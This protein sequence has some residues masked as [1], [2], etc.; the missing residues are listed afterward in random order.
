MAT[1]F[2]NKMQVK[3][4]SVIQQDVRV[5]L[6][7]NAVSTTLAALGDVDTLSLD[8]I[9]ESKVEEGIERIHCAA[10]AH[11]L[12][13][14][15]NF[16]DAVDWKSEASGWVLL[17]EDFMRFV[18]FE[19]SDWERPVFKA[20]DVDDTEYLHQS[21]RFKG[22]RGTPQK[23][24]CF[25]AFHPEGRML[26]FFSCKDETATV[27]RGVYLPYPNIETDADTGIKSVEVCGRCYKAI[28]YMIASL[29]ASAY[30]DTQKSDA[31]FELAK[32]AMI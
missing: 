2:E 25:I 6:N 32:S 16:G 24:V 15:Y 23:P 1:K 20:I 14:G 22:V 26:E 27:T 18:V 19:M 4:L 9:V 12:N 28:V 11:L 5:A 7:Q 21:S 17:P 10:P 30:G 29:T 31:L 13:G 8:E 3:Q